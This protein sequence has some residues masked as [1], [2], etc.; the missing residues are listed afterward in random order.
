MLG[1]KK[2]RLWQSEYYP[3]SRANYNISPLR[4]IKA[5]L[6]RQSI[7]AVVVFVIVLGILHGEIG[8]EN[9]REMVLAWIA[10]DDVLAESV[11]LLQIGADLLNRE[12]QAAI[13]DN[14]AKSNA[15]YGEMPF[16][17]RIISSYGW[18]KDEEKFNKGIIIEADEIGAVRA[19]ADG[20]VQTIKQEGEY[21]TL[22]LAHSDGVVSIY[23]NC[24][25][26]L[27]E[28]KT[29]VKKGEIIAYSGVCA[30]TKSRIYFELEHNGEPL[31][32]FGYLS[33]KSV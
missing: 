16:N 19:Y 12:I 33:D 2:E 28:E 13:G 3:E 15:E 5:K 11:T 22:I 18:Q 32:P 6:L 8:N 14:L 30:V 21:Y 25:K 20:V 29:S 26:V 24:S 9:S 1:G 17:G 4:N 31:E 23:G 7:I 10:K 27:T